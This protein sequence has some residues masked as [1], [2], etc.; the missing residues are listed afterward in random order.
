MTKQTMPVKEARRLF[1]ITLD[2][3]ATLGSVAPDELK[4]HPEYKNKRD[5][6]QIDKL[7]KWEEE[8]GYRPGTLGSI[9][10]KPDEVL[11]LAEEYYKFLY[12]NIDYIQYNQIDESGEEVIIKRKKGTAEPPERTLRILAYEANHFIERWVIGQDAF[13][14]SLTKIRTFPY[15]WEFQGFQ[16]N[17]NQ[18]EIF[19]HKQAAEKKKEDRPERYILANNDFTLSEKKA[20]TTISNILHKGLKANN[21]LIAQY[22][23]P[24]DRYAVKVHMKELY[25]AFGVKQITTS[26]GTKEFSGKGR[27]EAR[28]ALKQLGYK[29]VITTRKTKRGTRKVYNS[30][31]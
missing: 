5:Q 26:R 29:R 4:N 7:K 10:P 17:K 13:F 3:L 12:Q 28:E 15:S 11:K 21:T 16:T 14:A 2:N 6:Q 31:L 30:P 25:E 20:L 9:T 1:K 23:E 19:E 8:G 27:K 18:I 22:V 24:F